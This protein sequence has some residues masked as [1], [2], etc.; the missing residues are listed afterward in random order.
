M[1]SPPEQRR[2]PAIGAVADLGDA[3]LAELNRIDAL[4]R[5]Q[6]ARLRAGAAVPA[7]DQFRG[8]YISDADVDA[9]LDGAWP[10]TP[11]ALD[12]ASGQLSPA[13]AYP[14]LRALAERFAL[15]PFAV[16][17]L[18]ICLAP[19]VSL[20]Y[21]RLFAYLQDDVTRK[22]PS[23]D[24]V[25]NLLCP[26]VRHKL[27]AWHSFSPAAPLLAHELL[28]AYEEGGGQHAP[29][30][31][32]ALRVDER[33]VDFLLGGTALDQRLDAWARLTHPAPPEIALHLPGDVVARLAA[34]AEAALR[35]GASGPLLCL[36]GPEG[37]GRHAA[38]EAVCGALDLPLLTVDLGALL[39]DEEPPALLRRTVREARL[40]SA[41]LYLDG[42]EALTGDERALGVARRALG[43]LLDELPGLC[44]L[45]IAPDAPEPELTLRRRLVPV[46]FPALDHA[47]RFSLWRTRAGGAIPDQA[48]DELAGRFRLNAAQIQAAAGSAANAALGRDPAD[49]AVTLDDLFAASRRQATPRLGSLARKITP[50]YRWEHIVLP[51]DQRAQL[52]EMVDQVRYRDRVLETWGFDRTVP[53]GKGLN[54]LFSGPS[55][56]GKTMAAEIMAGALGIELYKVDLSSMVSKYIGETEKNLERLFSEAEHSSAILFFDEADAIFGKRSEVKDAHDRYANIEVGY[57]LQRIEE[58]EGVV[59]LATNL[60]KNMDDAFVRRLHMSIEFPFPEEE[61]RLKIWRLAFPTDAPMADDVDLGFMARRFKLTGGNIKNI[62]LAAAFLAAAAGA[63]I[64][65]AHLIRGTRRE[66]QKLGKLVVEAEFGPYLSLLKG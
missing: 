10:L 19:E 12:G 38:A 61:D 64:G 46:T 62:A 4:L 40:L 23:V 47:A 29:R 57:L 39:A 65:M 32:T 37:V 55:G 66:Y 41:A 11:A 6:V 2:L 3:L 54:A 51:P 56:T 14:P 18:L 30:L 28:V 48:I 34:V 33:I 7:E 21:E 25:L 9:I 26:S 35:D 20:S 5:A 58:F 22:R 36:R 24:L 53:R 42:A 15:D 49:G 8:L 45:A 60:R 27:A 43:P 31:A 59:I 17:A 1:M 16:D 50:R 52:I 63:P 44:F 13:V